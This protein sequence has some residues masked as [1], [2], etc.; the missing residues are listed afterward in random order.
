MKQNF[1]V[2]K[3]GLADSGRRLRSKLETSNSMRKE[4][5]IQ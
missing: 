2:K 5:N 3:W 1:I 4:L